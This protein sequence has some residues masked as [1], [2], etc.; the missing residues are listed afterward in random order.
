M[1]DEAQ[2]KVWAVY[3]AAHGII[4]DDEIN[5]RLEEILAKRDMEDMQT[6]GQKPHVAGKPQICLVRFDDKKQPAACV[7]QITKEVD[8]ISYGNS[9]P[10]DPN[11]GMSTG[12]GRMIDG[13]TC[14]PGSKRYTI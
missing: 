10:L 8:C 11:T 2:E 13:T 6:L 1:A 12:T 4:G 14:P 3:R 9:F 7:P 5:G